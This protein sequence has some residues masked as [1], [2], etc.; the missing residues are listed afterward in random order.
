ML[1]RKTSISRISD[2]A[3]RPCNSPALTPHRSL[4]QERRGAGGWRHKPLLQL[5]AGRVLSAA[6]TAPLFGSR[7]R[8]HPPPPYRH[9]A[10]P[11]GAQASDV[12]VRGVFLPSLRGTFNTYLSPSRRRSLLLP[13]GTLRKRP[14]ARRGET[15]KA[16]RRLFPAPKLP[17]PGQAPS[18]PPPPP[19]RNGVVVGGVVGGKRGPCVC[20]TTLR[21]PRTRLGKDGPGPAGSGKLP[22]AEDTRGGTGGGGGWVAVEGSPP[23]GPRPPL[24]ASGHPRPPP[25]PRPPPPPGPAAPRLPRGAAGALGQQRDERSPGSASLGHPGD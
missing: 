21:G 3:C 14:A 25:G 10:A 18:P 11:N 2:S 4:P 9:G 20:S 5:Q 16:R 6:H 7:P 1:N 24:S 22:R 8:D 15:R 19:G 13:R 17:G 12:G 23:R